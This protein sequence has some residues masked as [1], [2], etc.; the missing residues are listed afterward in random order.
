[1]GICNI[2]GTNILYKFFEAVN[3]FLHYVNCKNIFISSPFDGYKEICFRRL[4]K[5]VLYKQCSN[6]DIC[7]RQEN[8][9]H[10]FINSPNG[11][12]MEALTLTMGTPIHT[13]LFLEKEDSNIIWKR[14]SH[15]N[16]D[17]CGVPVCRDGAGDAS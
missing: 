15:L 17:V 3:Q 4:E 12:T 11:K 7:N 9:A 10:L 6:E 2:S 1:M 13:L 16:L 14:V 8:A 5:C